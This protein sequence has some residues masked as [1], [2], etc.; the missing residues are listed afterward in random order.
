[1]YLFIHDTQKPSA[2]SESPGLCRSTLRRVAAGTAIAC[3]DPV[4]LRRRVALPFAPCALCRKLPDPT[5]ACRR[6]MQIE[7]LHSRILFWDRA[8]L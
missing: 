1:M 4:L 6:F 3:V 5:H 8:K 7:I 2:G